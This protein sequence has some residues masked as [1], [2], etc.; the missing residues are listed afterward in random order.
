MSLSW[1]LINIGNSKE[2]AHSKHKVYHHFGSLIYTQP[3]PSNGCL[4]RLMKT[5]H[6]TDWKEKYKLRP[7]KEHLSDKSRAMS[8]MKRERGGF[9]EERLKCQFP[10]SSKTIK[11]ETGFLDEII[12]ASLVSL[13]EYF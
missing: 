7:I 5:T 3:L 12:R 9:K 10:Q 1:C 13:I 6:I 11:M 2:Y 8:E 4:K